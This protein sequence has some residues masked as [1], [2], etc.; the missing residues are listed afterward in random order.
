[1]DESTPA[2]EMPQLYREVLDAVA[3]LERLGD[4]ANA[5]EIRRRAI[6]TY[7]ARWDRSG[8]RALAKVAREAQV[9]IDA[10]PRAAV[11]LAGSR[12]PA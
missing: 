8:H 4:R 11:A 2:A 5:Y 3:R 6:R 9:R 7:S 12:E 10:A 1:M